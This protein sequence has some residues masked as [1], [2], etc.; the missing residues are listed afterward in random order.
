MDIPHR[1]KKMSGK[2]KM[3]CYW[4]QQRALLFVSFVVVLTFGCLG[5]ARAGGAAIKSDEQ[6]D[7]PL[8][9]TD[10]D[11]GFRV[12]RISRREG[13]NH[14][15]YFHNRPFVSAL[16]DEGDMMVFRGSTQIGPSKQKEEQLF[17]VNL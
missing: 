1:K 7:T 16:G 17:T 9:W 11:T 3:P 4:H 10:P 2:S 15:F 8:E 6:V 13:N 5:T 14:S 12:V